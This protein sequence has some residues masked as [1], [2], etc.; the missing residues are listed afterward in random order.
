MVS[1]ATGK[2]DSKPRDVL[3]V[4]FTDTSTDC[5]GVCSFIASIGTVGRIV[6]IAKHPRDMASLRHH[7]GIAF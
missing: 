7:G 6:Q 2:S 1:T 3:T 4:E 5:G